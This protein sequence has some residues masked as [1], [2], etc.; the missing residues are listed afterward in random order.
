MILYDIILQ[1]MLGFVIYITD[2]YSG[3]FSI[4]LA[5]IVFSLSVFTNIIRMTHI[6][7]PVVDCVQTVWIQS[8]I[9]TIVKVGVQACI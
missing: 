6:H 9:A 8:L 7:Y 1:G 4:I 3:D 5:E 2:H